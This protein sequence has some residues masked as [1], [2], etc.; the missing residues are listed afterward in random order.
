MQDLANRLARRKKHLGK[1][2]RRRGIT[3]YRLYE[4]DIPEDFRNKWIHACYEI[5]HGA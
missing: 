4:R 3:C 5:R 1:W 2:A